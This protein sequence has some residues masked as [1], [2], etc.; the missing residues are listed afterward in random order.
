MKNKRVYSNIRRVC[1]LV[2]GTFAVNW[3]FNS[4]MQEFEEVLERDYGD[5]GE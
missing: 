4:K 5:F 1:Y 3:F 2:W